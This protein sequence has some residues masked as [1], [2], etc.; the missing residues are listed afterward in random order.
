MST[1]YFL[2]CFE[3]D[4]K[5]GTSTPS[6]GSFGFV[7]GTVVERLGQRCV[8]VAESGRGVVSHDQQGADAAWCASL[9]KVN[10]RMERE[11]IDVFVT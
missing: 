3:F 8:Q 4:I 7:F 11:K 1:R 5:I 2:A 10:A 6:L 9:G